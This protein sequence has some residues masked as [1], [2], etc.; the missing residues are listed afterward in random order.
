MKHLIIFL[1][2]FVELF[3][4]S[5]NKEN[6]NDCFTDR[7]VTA[8]EKRKLDVFRNIK[9]GK[10]IQLVLI[11]DTVNYAIVEAGSHLLPSIVTSVEGEVLTIQNNNKCNWVR[12][13]KDSILIKLHY[14]DLFSIEMKGASKITNQDTLRNS[15]T[16]K[17]EFRDASGD[18]NLMVDNKRI[19]I[20]QHTGS[21]DVIVNGKTDD[22][23]VYMSGL[24][25][26]DY[27]KL[28]C[29]TAYVD[30]RSAADVKVYAYLAFD[31]RLRF[32]GDVYYRGAGTVNSQTIIGDGKIVKLP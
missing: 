4:F 20:I 14:T 23:S 12:T 30:T 26:G 5:C 28:Y 2:L 18:V 9:L 17:F 3:L 8:V 13:Y 1:M 11:E 19:E 10:R 22:L 31:F 27:S 7:G 6:M 21:S 25:W 24:G 16:L 32:S 15:D 29:R